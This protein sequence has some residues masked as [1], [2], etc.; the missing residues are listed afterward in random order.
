M[1]GWVL[2]VFYGKIGKLVMVDSLEMGLQEPCLLVS[3]TL[4]RVLPQ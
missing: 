3:M 2:V 4:C 1:M